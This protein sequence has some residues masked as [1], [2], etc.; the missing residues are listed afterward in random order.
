MHF[1]DIHTHSVPEADDVLAVV[2]GLPDC[3]V[4]HGCY[5]AMGLH[6]WNVGA[7]WDEGMNEL[8]EAVG[9]EKVC[10][11]GECGIDRV[12]LKGRDDARILLDYQIEA[13]RWQVRLAES[14]CKPVILHCVKGVDEIL[15]VKN[16]IRPVQRWIM[17]GFRG[18]AEQAFQL[19]S[20]GVE[21]SFGLH[22][23]ADAVRKAFS[24]GML[25]V[26][27]DDSGH[28]VREVYAKIADEVGVD[29][30]RL[31]EEVRSRFFQLLGL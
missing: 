26:E 24:A 18:G 23:D 3:V 9:D 17:H 21:L 7:D 31:A 25:W 15:K 8:M 10:M 12:V 28:D 19:M 29:V 13:F 27:T 11:V 5:G 2:N 30:S 16:E 4:R 6:P 22:H 1:V 14:V 20:K